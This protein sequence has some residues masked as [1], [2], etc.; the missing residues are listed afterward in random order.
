MASD[1]G[2]PAFVPNAFGVGAHTFAGRAHLR[3][4]SASSDSNQPVADLRV[5]VNAGGCTS[6]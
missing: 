6:V 1:D 3:G 2:L 5:T 4:A